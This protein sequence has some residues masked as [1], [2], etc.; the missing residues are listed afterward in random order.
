MKFAVIKNGKVV[1]IVVADKAQKNFVPMM[2]GAEIGATWDGQN[3]AYPEKR[4]EIDAK[5]A[6]KAVKDAAKA[7]GL[8]KLAS[9]AKLT[10]DE[11]AALFGGLE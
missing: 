10:P 4:A 2:D 9:A 11:V 7:S 1:N 6:A 5:D 3:F 8:D